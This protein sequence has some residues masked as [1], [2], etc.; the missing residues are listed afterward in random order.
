MPGMDGYAV[1]REIREMPAYVP[2]MM[3]MAKEVGRACRVTPFPT[4]TVTLKA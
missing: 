4:H 1:C 3:L 2:I